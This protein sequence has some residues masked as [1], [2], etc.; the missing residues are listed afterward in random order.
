MKYLDVAGC[1]I[2]VN[3]V[4]NKVQDW[5]NKVLSYANRLQ[6]ITSAIVFLQIY[7]ASVYLLP[8]TVIKEIDSLLK[9]FLWC[10]GEYTQGKAKVA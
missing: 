9:G 5:R 4:R 10:H 7:W 2:L 8:K 1:E 3:K 6:L